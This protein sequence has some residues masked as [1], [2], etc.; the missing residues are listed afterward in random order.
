MKQHALI[1]PQ[2]NIVRRVR[3]EKIDPRQLAG[4]DGL[5]AGYKWLPIVIQTNDTTTQT[6]YIKAEPWSEAVEKDRV[7]RSR[8]I[9]DMT[10]QEIDAQKDDQIAS[11]VDRVLAKALFLTLNEARE[12]NGKQ[13]ITANQ[14]RTWLKGQL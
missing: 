11:E 13:P 12:A 6:E 2:G 5:K 9:R 1:D 7:L 14:F 3:T 10:A 4:T 8:T